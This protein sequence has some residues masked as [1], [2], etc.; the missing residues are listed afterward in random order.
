MI[1]VIGP[2]GVGGLLA[3]LLHRAGVETT[4]V[5]RP[6]TAERIAAHGLTV[7]SR[8]FGTF[9]SDVA[10][11][12]AIP[13]GSAV[14]LAIKAY[15]LANILAD[16]AHSRPHEVLAVPNG[17]AHAD[18]LHAAV[19]APVACGAIR[20][21]SART[22]DGVI[23]HR[24]PFCMI[25]APA[26][27]EEWPTMR[28][29]ATAGVETRSQ[30]TETEVLWTKLR[31]LA[32]LA[33]LTAATDRP[34]GEAL[35]QDPGLTA[36]VLDEVAALAT[37]EGLPT[38]AGDLHR[39]LHGFDPSMHSSL[40]LDVRRGGPTELDALGGHLLTL[41]ARHGIAAPSLARLVDRIGAV[42]R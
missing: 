5:A 29:L 3:A 21:E 25:T 2:G 11:R 4:V 37:A 34:L 16:L 14:I 28:A 1:S 31:F 15:G 22:V 24:S 10:V 19:E 30:G 12:T 27:T 40:Q 33:L 36:G 17:V 8:Q 41:A 26:G 9:H 20:V 39:Q 38:A 6:A 32:P 42:R 35:R 13:R 18:L 23:V 7:E